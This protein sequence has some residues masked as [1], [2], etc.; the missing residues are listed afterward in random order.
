MAHPTH[1]AER[2]H[3]ACA[4]PAHTTSSAAPSGEP[5]LPA[6][7]FYVLTAK[8]HRLTT[9]CMNVTSKV[10]EEEE[11]WN[12]CSAIHDSVKTVT[13]SYAVRTQQLYLTVSLS[14]V[15]P[16]S[17]PQNCGKLRNTSTYLQLA[18]CSA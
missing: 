2:H 13:I 6:W 8:D 4:A 7:Q 14:V 10:G 3:G 15:L 17:D 12:Y 1:P 5:G 18:C 9:L 11:R 16:T